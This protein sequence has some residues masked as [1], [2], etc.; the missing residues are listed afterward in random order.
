MLE[1]SVFE[2][3]RPRGRRS[4]RTTVYSVLLHGTAIGVLVVV[5]LLQMQAVPIPQ[6]DSLFPPPQFIHEKRTDVVPPD[7]PAPRGLLPDP[8][9]V[10]APRVIPSEI[11]R[12]VEAPS[13]PTIDVG[14]SE[15]GTGIRDIFIETMNKPEDTLLV[16]PPPPPPP[17][18][19]AI[20]ADK[21]V[22]VSAGAQ[23]G[24]LI[25][26]VVPKYPPLA[27]QTH[28]QGVVVLEAIISK[29]G[30]IESLRVVSGHPFL[31]PAAID[32]V[33]Q[34]LYTPTLLNSEPV[35]VVTTITVNFSFQ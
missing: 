14:R 32:A 3:A 7:R 22:R 8:D 31:I 11:A 2:S 27:V 21:P 26:R 13:S 12:I 4:P 5:P 34:W 18:T 16:P 29:E 10:V 23:Q 35:S 15:R 9:A 1:D 30:T 24:R 17:E 20:P 33:Q 28:I 25:R 19:A 6:L